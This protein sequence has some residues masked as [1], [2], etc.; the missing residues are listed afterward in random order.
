MPGPAQRGSIR[1]TMAGRR[2]ALGQ[3]DAD[4]AAAARLDDVAADDGVGGPVGAFDE[5]V[6]LERA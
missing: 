3:R 4:D 1:S 5:H 2:V 6:G